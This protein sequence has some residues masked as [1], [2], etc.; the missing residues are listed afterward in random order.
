M[1]NLMII[2]TAFSLIAFGCNS[3]NDKTANADSSN[4]QNSMATTTTSTT[5]TRNVEVT[6][7]IKNSFEKSYPNVQD[8]K[9][10]KYEPV[11]ELE[12]ADWE[13]MG[14][15]APDTSD[16]TASFV[17]DNA[18]YQSWYTPQG[19]LI[20]SMS[21]VDSVSLPTPVTTTVHKQYEDYTYDGVIKKLKDKNKTAYQIKLKNG[22]D[23]VK[24]L[25]NENGQVIKKK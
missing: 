1:K 25:V 2:G 13:M 11:P 7:V 15:N 4:A 12:P 14:W 23:K 19:D 8:V 16:Y 10:V 24:I 9:W 6:P 21:D 18:N 17:S 22:N 20:G 5:T 3:S